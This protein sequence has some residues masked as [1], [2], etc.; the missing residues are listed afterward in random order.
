HQLRHTFA[1]MLVSNGVDIITAKTL[2]GHSDTDML[3]KIYAHCVPDNITK[4]TGMLGGILYGKAEK[5]PIIAP[6]F[7]RTA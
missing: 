7:V 2:M 4:A 3:T 6:D 5:T 1:T